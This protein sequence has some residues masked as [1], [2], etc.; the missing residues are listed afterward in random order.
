MA[1]SVPT[2]TSLASASSLAMA[3]SASMAPSRILVVPDIQNAGPGATTPGARLEFSAG[4]GWLLPEPGFT[5]ES[6]AAMIEQFIAAP[7]LLSRA[8]EKSRAL[9][10]PDAAER[11][12]DLAEQLI[13]ERRVAREAA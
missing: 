3:P 11:L 5:A 12:A 8:A 6:L 13:N 2:A 9:G 7:E 4:G 1:S 10:R